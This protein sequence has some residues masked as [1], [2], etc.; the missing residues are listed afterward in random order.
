MKGIYLDNRKV[1]SLPFTLQIK[2]CN[3]LLKP[4]HLI[5]A[6]KIGNFGLDTINYYGRGLESSL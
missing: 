1:H 5:S 4:L 3:L 2:G 6:F